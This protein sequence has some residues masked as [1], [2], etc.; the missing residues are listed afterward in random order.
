MGTSPSHLE[1]LRRGWWVGVLTLAVALA[2]CRFLTARQS[3]QYRSAVKV[4]VGPDPGLA[5]TSEILRT[6]ETLER[7]TVLATFA[8][9]SQSPQV[10]EQAAIAMGVAVPDLRPYRLSAAIVPNTNVIRIVSEGPAPERAADL[11]NAVASVFGAEAGRLYRPF[12]I[13]SLTRASAAGRPFLPDPRRNLVVAG[14]LG[15]FLGLGL[16]YAFGRLAALRIVL[17]VEQPARA[18]AAR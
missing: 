7:R 2:A 15:L 8:E 17:P 4:V 13:E 11:A 9:L 18:H 3:P 10:R 6:L 1:P 5:E 14:T 16:A 12:A